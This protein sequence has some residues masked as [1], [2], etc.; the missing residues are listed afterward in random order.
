MSFATPNR[1]EF[2][3]GFTLNGR[4]S[5]IAS[6][7]KRISRRY[8]GQSR[9]RS[10]CIDKFMKD[11][12]GHPRFELCMPDEQTYLNETQYYYFLYLMSMASEFKL[13]QHVVSFD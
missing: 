7:V 2:S 11:A 5:T 8:N 1:A 9:N 6:R 10:S 13:F 4:N 3:F 12:P